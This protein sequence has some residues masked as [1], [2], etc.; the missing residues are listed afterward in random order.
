M[1]DDQSNGK[2]RNERQIVGSK[3]QIN[4]RLQTLNYFFK[5]IKLSER[6]EVFCYIIVSFFYF[7]SNCVCVI[8]QTIK[9][10]IA[11]DHS[12]IP[13]KLDTD[14]FKR[15]SPQAKIFI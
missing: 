6:K 8:S 11:K 14:E 12:D 15:K 13:L 7:L 5:M 10:T 1:E 2:I 3:W 4:M 9:L